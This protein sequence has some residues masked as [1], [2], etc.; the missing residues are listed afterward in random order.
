MGRRLGGPLG[1]GRG[2]LDDLRAVRGL[3]A[4]RRRAGDQGHLRALGRPQGADARDD[5]AA[6]REDDHRYGAQGPADSGPEHGGGGQVRGAGGGG[7]EP[8]MQ[9]P[10]F[11]DSD[12]WQAATADE[13]VESAEPEATDESS[14]TG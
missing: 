3:P 8:A 11:E 7:G 6:G 9:D 5:E 1:A 2:R 14:V 4:G 10:G 13:A 12:P